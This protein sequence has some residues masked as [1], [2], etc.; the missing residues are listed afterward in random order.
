RERST[1]IDE[2]RKGRPSGGIGQFR[3]HDSGVFAGSSPI[4]CFQFSTD[5]FIR[6]SRR[7]FAP[8]R[9]LRR[10]HSARLACVSFK[11]VDEVRWTT[12]KEY[13]QRGSESEF[14]LT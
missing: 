2:C 11:G 3:N 9:P 12:K 5:A 13:V 14:S 4:D 10:Q 1:G 6:F 8:R 7:I